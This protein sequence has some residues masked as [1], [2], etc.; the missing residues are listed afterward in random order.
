[1]LVLK[2][3]RQQLNTCYFR[4]DVTDFILCFRKSS[5]QIPR[6]KLSFF[7][8]QFLFTNRLPAQYHQELK[9]IDY[10]GEEDL[11]MMF[12]GARECERNYKLARGYSTGKN[13]THSSY[14]EE[15]FQKSN[16]YR[17]KSFHSH[18]YGKPH[19]VSNTAAHQSTTKDAM[20]LDVIDLSSK[21][22]YKCHKKDTFLQTVGV[23]SNLLSRHTKRSHQDS[24][25]W[26]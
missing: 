11:E 13:T 8:Q 3:I 24:W 15:S 12:Q 4:G 2:E 19:P 14:H 10:K 7:K 25:L 6:D 20:D 23:E 18:S 5:C 1:M 17:S 21:E 22:C 16:N 26:I 9:K